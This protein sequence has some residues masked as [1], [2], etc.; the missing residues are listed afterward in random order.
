MFEK[1]LKEILVI[2]ALGWWK[3]KPT[4]TSVRIYLL[5]FLLKMAPAEYTL[6]VL[7]TGT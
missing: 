1:I 4:R 3:G 2:E 6:A 7:V 5:R